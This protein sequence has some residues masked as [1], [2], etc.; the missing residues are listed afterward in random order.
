MKEMETIFMGTESKARKRFQINGSYRPRQ[1]SL[2]QD[3]RYDR[4]RRQSWYNISKRGKLAQRLKPKVG[5]LTLEERGGHFHEGLVMPQREINSHRKRKNYDEIPCGIQIQNVHLQLQWM[6][7]RRHIHVLHSSQL[8][9]IL[10][11]KCML[12]TNSKQL[13]QCWPLKG[14]RAL[15]SH[16]SN[17]V[18]NEMMCKVNQI[19]GGVNQTVEKKKEQHM[20]A[21][22]LY[23]FTN[24]PVS[25]HYN[26]KLLAPPI[27]HGWAA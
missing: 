7:L 15:F 18:F 25:G 27:L 8:W 16:F 14:W 4:S 1:R 23:Q 19:Q 11:C 3:P 13:W 12:L 10:T 9:Y 20:L 5:N 17:F 26:T 24:Y 2:S 22:E 6:R 21:P